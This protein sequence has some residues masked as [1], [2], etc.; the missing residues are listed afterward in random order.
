MVVSLILIG[1][2]CG[3]LGAVLVKPLNLGLWWNSVCGAIGGATVGFAPV[4]FTQY[5][6]Q[7]WYVWFLAAGLAGMALMLLMGAVAALG[8]RR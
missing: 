4:L 3:N 5:A 7:P 8:Y 6:A 1:I 2:V